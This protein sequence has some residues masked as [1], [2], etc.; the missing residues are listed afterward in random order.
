MEISHSGAIGFASGICTVSPF[1]EGCLDLVTS[2]FV[3]P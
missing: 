3:L 1:V 2:T